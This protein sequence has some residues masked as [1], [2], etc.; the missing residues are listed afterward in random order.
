LLTAPDG[1]CREEAGMKRMRRIRTRNWTLE[2]DRGEIRIYAGSGRLTRGKG[3]VPKPA[4]YLMGEEG[5]Y[6]PASLQV[7]EEGFHEMEES[8]TRIFLP[9]EA[10]LARRYGNRDLKFAKPAGRADREAHY[11]AAVKQHLEMLVSVMRSATRYKGGDDA[12]IGWASDREWDA[13]TYRD[14]GY[15][16]GAIEAVLDLARVSG[17]RIEP[18]TE[19]RAKA[20]VYTS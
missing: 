2:E 12:F 14:I 4:A 18:G 11:T 16:S 15:Y 8:G 7:V 1:G 19:S 6:Q 10:L 3:K 9:S 17:V 13:E 5:E 20:Y